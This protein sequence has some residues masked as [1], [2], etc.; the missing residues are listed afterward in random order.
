M[1]IDILIDKIT[2]CLIDT[3][4]GKA[5]GDD[6]IIL[7]ARWLGWVCYLPDKLEFILSYHF[8]PF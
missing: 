8:L 5:A 7:T 1:E 3:K 4:T 2:D 6:K